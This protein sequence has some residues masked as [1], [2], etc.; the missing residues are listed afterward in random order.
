[1]DI[2]LRNTTDADYAFCE[3]IHHQGM[4]PYVEPLWGWDEKFQ[5]ERYKR[6][7]KPDRIKI[8]QLSDSDIGYLETDYVDMN[9]K[10]VNLFVTPT[11]RGKGI[12]SQ[13]IKGLIESNKTE[14]D[15]ITLNV[16]NNNPAKSLYE[17]LGFSFLEQNDKTLT[18]VL[19]FCEDS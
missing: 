5:M 6:L 15:Q 12:G 10:I 14:I 18:Y 16:L 3:H 9:L 17:R 8:I 2:K 1:M 13:V 11:F 4:R 7:W 19:K